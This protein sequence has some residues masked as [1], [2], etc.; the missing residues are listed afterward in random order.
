MRGR[1][2][3]LL[4]SNLVS[5]MISEGSSPIRVPASALS[6]PRPAGS[7]ASPAG[8]GPGGSGGRL[9]A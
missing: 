2:L 8:E 7:P 5:R 6:S 1:R 4:F 9:A 3:A